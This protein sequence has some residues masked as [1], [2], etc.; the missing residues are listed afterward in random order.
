[1]AVAD[2]KNAVP[3]HRSNIFG[4]PLA[5][6]YFGAPGYRDSCPFGGSDLK[7][8]TTFCVQ[9]PEARANPFCIPAEQFGRYLE[10]E[11]ETGDAAELQAKCTSVPI[12]ALL[13]DFA[14]RTFAIKEYLSVANHIYNYCLEEGMLPASV[15][16]QCAYITKANFTTTATETTT[17]STVTTLHGGRAAAT[18]GGWLHTPDPK[19]DDAHP[20]ARMPPIFWAILSLIAIAWIVGLY[21]FV[22]GRRGSGDGEV[23]GSESGE[24]FLLSARDDKP[25]ALYV[26][27]WEAMGG[28]L[29]IVTDKELRWQDRKVTELT[30]LSPTAFR[31]V[32]NG[33][34]QTAAVEDEGYRL[35][36]SNGSVWV[37]REESTPLLG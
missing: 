32:R 13:S 7:D 17:S 20:A 31:I 11:P 2:K 24:E 37:R 33:R 27:V 36:W 1:V 6:C 22:K 34:V 35:V 19:K 5:V 23:S 18:Q 25:R 29:Q 14:E 8:T 16:K 9:P 21:I 15:G 3:K 30:A 26:G 4:N 28:K 10:L 12:E